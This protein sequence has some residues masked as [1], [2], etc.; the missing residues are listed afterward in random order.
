MPFDDGNLMDTIIE[1]NDVSSDFRHMST[2][3]NEKSSQMELS[4]NNSDKNSI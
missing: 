2:L 3:K 4:R 1:K